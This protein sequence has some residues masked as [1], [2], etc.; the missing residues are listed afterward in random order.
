MTSRGNACGRAFYCY[1][2]STGKLLPNLPLQPDDRTAEQM[3]E[4]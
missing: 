3:P 4:G 1:W 2:R